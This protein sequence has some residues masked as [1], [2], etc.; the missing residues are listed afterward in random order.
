MRGS[1][2]SD[3][4]ALVS[5]GII[6]AGAGLTHVIGTSGNSPWDHP[7]GCGAHMTDDGEEMKWSGSSP[8]V[9]GS[10]W[11]KLRAGANPGIIP[12]GAG[13]TRDVCLRNL[14]ARGSSPR[15]RGSLY[16]EDELHCSAGIIPAGAGLTLLR[17]THLEM[18]GDHPRG[19]GAHSWRSDLH[20]VEPGS[21][22]RVRGSLKPTLSSAPV[23]GIIPAGAGLTRPCHSPRT[24]TR[25]H[26]R[27]CGAHRK[28]ITI[29]LNPLGSSPRVR[30]S[31]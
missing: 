19:C 29:H 3:A 23:P 10:P 17:R 13:L 27:G 16:Y 24:A 30:G 6:P 12:A 20:V 4:F 18:Y 15:V 22:P 14:F 8:R 1:L 26:P 21:S 7:R 31:P 9:R 2:V 25:D 28:R 11:R 5:L